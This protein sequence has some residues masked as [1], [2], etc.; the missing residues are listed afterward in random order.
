[1]STMELLVNI[2]DVVLTRAPKYKM[3][4]LPGVPMDLTPYGCHVLSALNKNKPLKRDKISPQSS[5]LKL[6]TIVKSEPDYKK[7]SFLDA[8][9]T[10]LEVGIDLE[11]L[12]NACTMG[13][14]LENVEFVG[15]TMCDTFET[16]SDYGEHPLNLY[17]SWKNDPDTTIVAVDAEPVFYGLSRSPNQSTGMSP[18]VRIVASRQFADISRLEN[19]AKRDHYFHSSLRDTSPQDLLGYSK[20]VT[21]KE[22]RYRLK[23]GQRVMPVYTYKWYETHTKKKHQRGFHAIRAAFSDHSRRESFLQGSWDT[24]CECFYQRIMT[25]LE[26]CRCSE[27][28]PA[29]DRCTTFDSPRFT[30]KRRAACGEFAH[31]DCADPFCGKFRDCP[32]GVQTMNYPKYL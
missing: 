22:L 32:L 12:T 18:T 13:L 9:G 17:R 29:D 20:V 4:L 31:W 3:D 27:S 8:D 30:L 16:V 7:G 25:T 5:L 24:E 26:V 6:T 1:M 19:Q 21:L 28:T 23:Y 15:G 10:T 11:S 14:D 2:L